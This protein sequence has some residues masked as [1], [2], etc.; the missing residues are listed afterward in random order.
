MSTDEERVYVAG[1]FGQLQALDIDTGETLCSV[2][3]SY[4]KSDWQ[5]WFPTLPL[6]TEDLVISTVNTHD[7]WV[8]AREKQ[9]GADC[10]QFAL[11]ETPAPI[12]NTTEDRLLASTVT[13]DVFALSLGDGTQGWRYRLPEYGDRED[14][15]DRTRPRTA[16]DA[17]ASPGS[18]HLITGQ[19]FY[20]GLIH[21]SNGQEVLELSSMGDEISSNPATFD[22]QPLVFDEGSITIT[23]A[24]RKARAYDFTGKVENEDSVRQWRFQTQDN[25]RVD[26]VAVNDRHMAITDRKETVCLLDVRENAADA[27]LDLETSV[28]TLY[29]AETKLIVETGDSVVAFDYSEL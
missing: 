2:T 21:Q 22:G 16:V 11:R 6:V 29:S 20:A 12:I 9:T 5:S 1:E 7:G 28:D 17:I 14:P 24:G 19:G 4:P 15:N 10:W 18:Y 26:P 13:G 23:F 25:P 27:Y 8:L 3:D